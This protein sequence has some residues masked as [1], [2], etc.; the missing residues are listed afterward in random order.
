MDAGAGG[1]TVRSVALPGFDTPCVPDTERVMDGK[2]LAV[3]AKLFGQ[4]PTPV[5]VAEALVERYFPALDSRDCVLEP[6]CGDGRFLQAIPAHVPAYG[7]ELDPHLAAAAE[8]RTGRR[9]FAGDFR[10]V[11]LDIYPTAIIGNPPFKLGLIDEFLDRSYQLLPTGGVV[12]MIIPAYMFQT[13]ARVVDYSKRWSLA[14]E[15]IPR[16]IFHGLSLPLLFAVFSKDARRTL[17]GFALY[18]ETDAAKRLSPEAQDI[19][20]NKRA[21]GSV[22]REV[23]DWAL[24]ELG[25]EGEVS[26]IYRLVEGRRP[27]ENRFWREKLR[28]TL[29]R[30]FVRVGDARYA[31]GPVALGTGA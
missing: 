10:T 14:Q 20:A 19:L 21:R 29:N 18:P 15:M 24:T 11:P 30:Y 7:V 9:V 23:V 4:Y 25:G 2:S 22:W 16:N 31:R 12:G 5:W 3:N 6:A 26:Q 13:A 17:V 27:T 28:Q 8:R 1:L